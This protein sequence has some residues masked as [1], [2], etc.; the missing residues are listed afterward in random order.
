M[1]NLA[2]R[3]DFDPTLGKYLAYP[4]ENMVHILNT[5]D[6]TT[7]KTLVA[8]SIAAAFSIVQFSPCGNFLAAASE[9]GDVVIWNVPSE[10]SINCSKLESSVTICAMVW[11]PTGRLNK[12]KSC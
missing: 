11:N 6:W 10:S 1:Q 12:I 2:G 3:I 4:N 8:D 9:D 7:Y 5:E